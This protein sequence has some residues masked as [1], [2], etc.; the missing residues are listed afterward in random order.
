MNHLGLAYPQYSDYPDRAGSDLQS[1]L[2]IGDGNI[3]ADVFTHAHY[4]EL[5]R[6]RAPKEKKLLLDGP[7][8]RDKEKKRNNESKWVAFGKQERSK[9]EYRHSTTD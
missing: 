4:T 6:P 8:N 1:S 7:G 5:Y 3:T 2:Q 9:L